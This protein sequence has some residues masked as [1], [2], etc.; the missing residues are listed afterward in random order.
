MPKNANFFQENADISKI[1]GS[2]VL[3]DIF[4]ETKYVFVLMHQI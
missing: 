3:K 1:K 2:L 4:S